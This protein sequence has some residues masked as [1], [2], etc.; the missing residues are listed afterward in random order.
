MKADANL[1]GSR[2]GCCQFT[3]LKNLMGR[4]GP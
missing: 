2:L 3:D 1:T 4:A